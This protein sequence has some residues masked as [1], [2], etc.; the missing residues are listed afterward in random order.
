MRNFLSVLVLLSCCF[1]GFSQEN[2]ELIHDGLTRTYIQYIP[3]NV[4][5]PA[6]VVLNLHGYTNNADFQMGYSGMNAVADEHGFIVIY[7]Q[8]TPDALGINHWNAWL[9]E[10]DVDDMGFL[11]AI[12]DELEANYDADPTRMY[13]CGFSNGGI[14]SYTLACRQ[15]ERFAAV[16]SVAGTMNPDI[17]DTCVPSR[18]FP[19]MH[20]HGSLDLIV[21]VN[22]TALGELTDFGALKSLDETLYFWVNFNA[23]CTS[24]S[25]SDLPNTSFLDL[26]SVSKTVYAACNDDVQCW[27][28]DV[29]GGGHSW[30]GAFP[31]VVVGNTNQ[32][33][34]ASSEIWDFFSLHTLALP[35]SVQPVDINS[36]KL[37][38]CYLDLRGV[39]V[40]LNEY[41]AQGIYVAVY[42][43]GSTRLYFHH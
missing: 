16:A 39:E 41:L 38:R 22:G 33:I 3:N 34:D 6:P 25:S 21:P 13:S 26:C 17:Y 35:Q 42:D 31:L 27:R 24:E 1:Q 18:S 2:M 5:S 10:D 4:Q 29:N 15:S 32:D 20:V 9:A 8:G 28:Y 7:P 12:L 36:E 30:P 37:P 40:E 23:E 43:D 11:L 19:V 14:M